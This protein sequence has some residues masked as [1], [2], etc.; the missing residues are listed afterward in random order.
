[1]GDPS[2]F[3]RKGSPFDWPVRDEFPGSKSTQDRDYWSIGACELWGMREFGNVNCC[4]AHCCAPWR[5]YGNALRY[6]GIDPGLAEVVSLASRFKNENN[7]ALL[8]GV[9]AVTGSNMREKLRQAL[10]ISPEGD[11]NFFLRLFCNPCLECQEV[12]SVLV[13]YRTNVKLGY[14]NAQYGPVTGCDCTRFYNN[15]ERID[16][17]PE[18]TFDYGAERTSN[19]RIAGQPP[20][21]S[22]LRY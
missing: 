8:G 11:G 5:V 17:P 1:M 12:D 21:Q 22:M 4:C 19:F 2:L 7:G 15:G 16:F 10:G 13:M 9:A 14:P 3:V 6:A 18:G 20:G